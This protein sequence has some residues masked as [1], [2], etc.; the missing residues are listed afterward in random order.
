MSGGMSVLADVYTEMKYTSTSDDEEMKKW[1]KVLEDTKDSGLT[2]Y[3]HT[4]LILFLYS[5]LTKG[6]RKASPFIFRH[7]M[8]D[9]LASLTPE[10]KSI[11]RNSLINVMWN[12]YGSDIT[13]YYDT[14]WYYGTEHSGIRDSEKKAYEK[15]EITST[16]EYVP[17]GLNSVVL[18]EIRYFNRL[19]NY[20]KRGKK[21]KGNDANNYIPL[22]E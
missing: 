2:P 10:E 13:M 7:T 15:L 9:V 11:I 1:K 18:V 22:Y 17:K 19:L 21:V 6:N 3:L 4:I 8:S 12:G 5:F 14:V 20:I 16:F